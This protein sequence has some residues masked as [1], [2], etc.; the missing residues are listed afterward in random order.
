MRALT[1]FLSAL[2]GTITIALRRAHPTVVIGCGLGV[3][4]LALAGLYVAADD[5]AGPGAGS[6]ALDPGGDDPVDPAGDSAGGAPGANDGQGRPLIS[7]MSEAA[8]RTRGVAVAGVGDPFATGDE[9]VGSA[10]D[11]P[12]ADAAAGDDGAGAGGREGAPATSS[13]SST[14]DRTTTTGPGTTTSTTAATTTTTA[15]PQDDGGGGP[16]G[17]LLD[18][19]GLG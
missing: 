10:A 16:L 13:T 3:V 9:G 11:A 2:W 18:L 19:L 8:A 7:G 15:A 12:S 17:G 6:A 5:A 4:A 1:D 14:T